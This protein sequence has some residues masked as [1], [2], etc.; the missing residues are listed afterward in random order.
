MQLQTQ[1]RLSWYVCGVYGMEYNF[2][3]LMATIL[4]RVLS[5]RVNLCTASLSLCWRKQLTSQSLRHRDPARLTLLPVVYQVPFAVKTQ[6]SHE[7]NGNIN[8]SNVRI[9]TN[10]SDRSILQLLPKYG[11]SILGYKQAFREKQVCD[12]S[13]ATAGNELL[14]STVNFTFTYQRFRDISTYICLFHTCF[15]IIG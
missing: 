4:W 5:T 3:Y 2:L 11:G 10:Q 7:A 8:K 6:L 15:P 13:K 12:W 1:H 9:I 14:M